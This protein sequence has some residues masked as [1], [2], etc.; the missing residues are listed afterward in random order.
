VVNDR[1]NTSANGENEGQ[2]YNVSF[3]TGYDFSFGGLTVTPLV[4]VDYIDTQID[5]LDET[6]GQGWALHVDNQEFNSLTT[7]VGAQ[8]SYAFSFPWG[9][10]IP[11]A[12]AEWVHEFSN[13]SRTV[14]AHFIQDPTQTK[15]NIL[16]DSPD[17]DFVTLGA[18]MSAQFEHGISAFVNYETVVGHKYIEAHSFSTGVRFELSF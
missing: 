3:S 12:R 5:A 15:F 11:T 8:T 9:V 14:T 13:D 2:E 17:R 10:L 6:G 7:A 4:R 1:V 16:T 18:G